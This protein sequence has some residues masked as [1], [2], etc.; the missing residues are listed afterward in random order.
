MKLRHLIYGLLAVAAML[1]FAGCSGNAPGLDP[2]ISF[3]FT[4]G[5][6]LPNLTADTVLGINT[7]ATV[8]SGDQVT[9]VQWTEV[10]Q[11]DTEETIGLFSTPESLDTNWGV[12]SP[13]LIVAPKN[14]TLLLTVKTLNG[15]ETTTPIELIILPPAP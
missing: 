15:G 7:T 11:S 12:A 1:V 8:A 5:E 6:E 10:P 13:E 9:D 14:V 3:E 2:V 4:N